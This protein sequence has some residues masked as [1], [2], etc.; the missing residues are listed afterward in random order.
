MT[1][2][3]VYLDY[4]ASALIRP[5]AEAAVARAMAAGGN[6]SSVHGLGR[7]ARRTVEAAREKVARLVNARPEDVIFTGGGTEA[8]NLAISGSAA[9]R[10][11]IS[12]VEHDSVREAAA[13]RPIEP[14]ILATGSDGVV[15]IGSL[16]ALLESDNTPALVSVM[17]ANNETGAIQPVESVAEIAHARG[18]LV[19]CDA[20]QAAG[21]VAVD[22]ADL[23]VDML[24]LS[25]HKIGGPQGVGAL[26]LR[27]GVAL[28]PALHGGGQER[29]RRSG[30]ENVPGIAGFGAA[31]EVALASLPESGALALLRDRLEARIRDLAPEA[32][33]HAA[34]APRLPNTSCLSMP[35]VASE[36]QVV[37]FDL[38]G[39]MI[40]AGAA[41]SSGKVD[42][43]GVLTAMSIGEELTASAIRVSLGWATAEQD[44]ERFL[45]A[46]EALYRRLGERQRS[47]SAALHATG[48]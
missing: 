22:L 35:G 17:L 41:C 1:G 3:P 27:R 46:W 45:A 32:C 25:S 8:N 15:D 47:G 18:A 33:V 40:S 14:S 43:S 26:I 4:N 36:T 31:A 21:K 19:H 13:A 48:V 30:T 5:E 12:S 29:G 24:S 42:P 7:A 28:A 9:A 16:S 20:V 2:T 37:A 11:V 6:P 38:D 39:V 44:V 34:E 23:D 10:L